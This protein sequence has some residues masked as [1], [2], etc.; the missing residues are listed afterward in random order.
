MGGAGQF[1]PFISSILHI[2]VF[3]NSIPFMMFVFVETTLLMMVWVW[4]DYTIL[5]SGIALGLL[6]C[7]L[8]G[9]IR[10]MGGMHDG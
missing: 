8:V 4:P 5:L 1:T 9:V 6:V 10:K 3:I 7:F 2:G